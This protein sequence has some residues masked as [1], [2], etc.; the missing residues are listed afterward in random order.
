MAK[1]IFVTGGVCSG[2][3]KG[4]AGASIGMLMKAAGY[5]VA[6]QKLDPYLNVDPGTMNPYQHG[7]VF[8]TKD[9]A[10]TDLDIGHYERF[11]DEEFTA[12][13]SVSTGQVYQ[14]VLDKE[15]EGGYLGKTIQIIPH[16]T[17]TIKEY[18]R[19][20][21]KKSDADIFICEI[22]GTVG[23]I[24]AE[25]YLEAIRQLHH[26]EGHHNV[27]FVHLVLL[28]Y[29]ASSGELKTKPAQASVKELRKIGINADIILCRFDGNHMQKEHLEK[30]ALFCDVSPDA[31]IPAPTIR[32]IY[33]VPLNFNKAN[34]TKLISAHFRLDHREPKLAQW[35]AF[36]E[37]AYAD[38]PAV[39]IALVGKYTGLKDAYYS[40]IEAVKAAGYANNVQTDI[41]WVDSEKIE[42][43]GVEGKEEWEK[44]KKA[45][46]VV[47]MGGFGKRGV[48]GKIAV[49]RYAREN[50]VP[51]FGLCLGMQIIA[52]E[53]ARTVLGL[54]G[55][56]ST[57][58]DE[59]TKDPVIYLMPSQR[60]IYKKGGTMRLGEYACAIRKGTKSNAAYGADRII[61]RHRHRYEFN[62]A[63]KERFEKNGMMIVG[64]NPESG[65]CEIIESA[66]HPW[67][68]GVQFHPEF[69][70]R[71][72]RPHPLFRDFVRACSTR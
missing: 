7:E 64:T 35:E 56:N 67:F 54:S 31:V 3:G 72:L 2:L 53:F 63:Y 17:D 59:Q 42:S 36:V 62:D 37:K 4:I 40:V 27:L 13:S 5:K 66:Q 8:V 45:K 70:S 47:V 50:N 51:Y 28:P 9:G 19:T 15:R 49:A 22:G 26:E 39:T 61:E 33:E 25:P 10:E 65:L 6:M 43:D 11:I 14:K 58:F 1:Y 30:I 55:A 12:L 68:V 60:E 18:I 41:I 71:P 16:I 48:E 23:D 69:L 57:E 21:A 46:G 52:I 29:L 44:L 32:S 34:I 20:C 24:E 38:L